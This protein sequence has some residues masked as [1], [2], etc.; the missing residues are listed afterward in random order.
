METKPLF[1]SRKFRIMVAD[2][3]VS[4]VLYFSVKYLAP[5]IVADIKFL[6]AAFQPVVWFVIN[7]IAK[8]D[9]ALKANSFYLN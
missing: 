3:V 4:L 9:A 8:E 1:K 5:D 7:G 2:V 6:I